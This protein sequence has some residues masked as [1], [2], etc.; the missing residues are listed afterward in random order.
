MVNVDKFKNNVNSLNDS[1]SE[2]FEYV[3]G[4]NMKYVKKV[5]EKYD[6]LR[7]ED[8]IK[9]WGDKFQMYRNISGNGKIHPFVK[10]FDKIVDGV[11]THPLIYYVDFYNDQEFKETASRVNELWDNKLYKPLVCIILKAFVERDWDEIHS[12][13]D[14]WRGIEDVTI[15]DVQDDIEKTAH[16]VVETLDTEDLK[17]IIKFCGGI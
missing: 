4:C 12:A 6:H 15:A 9:D 8:D 11:I 1:E 17:A 5:Y 7:L 3:T 13:F 14:G 2:I 10:V 16:I